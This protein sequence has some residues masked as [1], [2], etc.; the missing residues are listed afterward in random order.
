MNITASSRWLEG[1]RFLVQASSGHAMVV[2]ADRARNTA[3]SP[4]ELVLMGLC[5]C[6][7]VD[8]VS[9]LRKKRQTVWDVTVTAEAE[10]AEA[11]PQ[12]YTA[13]RLVYRITGAGVERK[14]VD[15]AVRL[16]KEKYCSVSRML[17]KT[18]TITH[19]IM[20]MEAETPRREA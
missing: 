18:A 1:E 14:A 9:I 2:D 8:V 19:E 4:M 15:D 16:S 20:V 12:V 10:R 7:S 6:T 11:P 17:E 3:P 5:S 13:I